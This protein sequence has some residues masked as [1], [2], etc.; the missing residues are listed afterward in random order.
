V[1]A[2]LPKGDFRVLMALQFLIVVDSPM[3]RNHGLVAILDPD[4]KL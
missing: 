3:R 2:L 4:E 1:A